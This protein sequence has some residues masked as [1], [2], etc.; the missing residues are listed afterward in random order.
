M[1]SNLLKNFDQKNLILTI[2]VTMLVLAFHLN[3]NRNMKCI[4]LIHA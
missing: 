1:E 3:I 2:L 4:F